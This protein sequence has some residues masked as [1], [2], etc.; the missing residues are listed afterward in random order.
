MFKT[1]IPIKTTTAVTTNSTRRC[2]SSM[3]IR[4]RNIMDESDGLLQ[5][6]QK[7]IRLS[8]SLIDLTRPMKTLWKTSAPTSSSFSSISL[9]QMH[10]N[11]SD[12]K[13]PSSSS[14]RTNRRQANLIFKISRSIRTSYKT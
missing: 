14:L 5:P 6:K 11:N 9:R 2:K 8:A 13:T 1:T 7:Q 12:K 3:K 10:S 4:G